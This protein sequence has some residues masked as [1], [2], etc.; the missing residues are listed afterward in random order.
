[1]KNKF[2]RRNFIQTAAGAAG[3]A[4]AAKTIAL[5]ETAYAQEWASG[6]NGT[7]VNFG[8]IG[9]GMQG[10]GL[11]KTAV[12]LPGTKCVAACDLWDGRQTLAK[13]IAGP[14]IV[15]TR[16][17]QELL[18]N[19]DIQA[20]IVAVPD[21]WHKQIV[22]DAVTAGKDVYC[23]KP[24]SH[25]V[26]DG[27]AMV[28]A[29]KKSGRIVQIGSQRTS[30]ALLAKAKQ[31][32][33]RRA[34]SAS[35]SPSNSRSVATIPPARGSIRRLPAS[36][37]TTSTGTPGSAPRPRSPSIPSPTRAGAA[38]RNTAPASP[39]TSWCIWSAA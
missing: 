10:S 24:M 12:E 27:A 30:S 3:L 29:A 14:N 8:I 37:P 33:R 22:V 20:L 31:T 28:A 17:Y 5:P 23:E 36:R 11:L 39:A 7:L 32:L 19:Q 38:G 26:A 34:P 1:M 15:V 18:A 21:H 16:K 13:E 25:T 2:T 6:P 35:C 9:I 4:L